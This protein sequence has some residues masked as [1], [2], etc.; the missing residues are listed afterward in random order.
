MEAL[1]EKPPLEEQAEAYGRSMRIM[2]AAGRKGLEG[3][4]VVSDEEI[5]RLRSEFD[6]AI[7]EMLKTADGVGEFLTIERKEDFATNQ[8]AMIVANN[9]EPIKDLIERGYQVSLRE[10][11]ED[12]DPRMMMQAERDHSDGILFNNYVE[13]M[14]N[15]AEHNTVFA[16]S[17]YPK[18]GAREYGRRFV[19]ELGYNDEFECATLQMYNKQGNTLKTR[20]LSIDYSNLDILADMLRERGADVPSD[21]SDNTLITHPILGNM[22]YEEACGFMDDFVAEYEL[23]TGQK[24]KQTTTMELVEEQKDLIS[25]SF[26]FLYMGV[27]E[28]L[29]QGHKTEYLSKFVSEIYKVADRMKAQERLAIQDIDHKRDFDRDDARIM[30]GAVLYSLAEKFRSILIVS[31]D[32]STSSGMYKNAAK[33]QELLQDPRAFIMHMGGHFG[34]GVKAKRAYGGCGAL[35]EFSM[36]EEAAGSP[37]DVF[38]GKYKRSNRDRLKN[39]NWKKGICRIKSCDSKGKPVEVGPCRICKNCEKKFDKGLDPSKDPVKSNNKLHEKTFQ[40]IVAQMIQDAE[41]YANDPDNKKNIKV[42]KE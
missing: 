18:E 1:K 35:F 22:T 37:Q 26:E 32:H 17:A 23:K 28:S 19:K 29:A 16:G 40:D 9:G 8:D 33:A 3:A 36:D 10:S 15:G 6:T 4:N 12:K 13:P 14:F 42:A 39:Y 21:V 24:P 20:T 27:A 5:C 11:S 34:N 7:G 41:N 30:H 25:R 2:L 38:G 31:E